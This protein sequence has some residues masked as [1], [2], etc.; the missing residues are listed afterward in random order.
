L[1][2]LLTNSVAFALNGAAIVAKE[3]S[4][5]HSMMGPAP[6]RLMNAD[7]EQHKTR[8]LKMSAFG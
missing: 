6:V 2:L 8:P 1:L 3:C 4:S 7:G 5:C